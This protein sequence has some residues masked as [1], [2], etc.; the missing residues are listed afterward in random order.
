[1]RILSQSL[2]QQ[3]CKSSNWTVQMLVCFAD[4]SFTILVFL[5]GFVLPQLKLS[6]SQCILAHKKP[7]HRGRPKHFAEFY[8]TFATFWQCFC[9]TCKSKRNC[10]LWTF[11]T[12]FFESPKARR[13]TGNMVTKW[14][15]KE[16]ES[17]HSNGI[18]WLNQIDLMELLQGTCVHTTPQT[19]FT[20]FTG[21]DLPCS[22]L[23]TVCFRC[24]VW[25]SAGRCFSECRK[26]FSSRWAVVLSDY[27]LFQA[28][29]SFESN[30]SNGS[31]PCIY[32]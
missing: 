27:R 6:A 31:D 30:R 28:N 22:I 25:G 19:A 26:L 9:N 20:A 4:T 16:F 18:I 29:L 13:T 7:K 12:E 10:R 5:T 21:R 32:M 8:N 1:M 2:G 23:V 11:E 15:G 24:T 3:V 14:F 17:N